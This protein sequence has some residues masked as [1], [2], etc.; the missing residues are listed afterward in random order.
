MENKYKIHYTPAL[1]NLLKE[2]KASVLITT[3]QAGKLIAISEK[4]GEIHQLPVSFKKPMG[5][6]IHGKKLA[7][8]CIDEIQFFSREV[9]DH[10]RSREGLQDFDAIYLHRASYHTG[11]M[12]VHDMEFGDGMLWGV[13]TLFSC[14]GVYDINFSFRPKWKPPFISG[15]APEDRCHL[16]GMAMVN[17]MPKYVTA[18]SNDNTVQGWR[19]DKLRSGILMEVPSGDI[20]LENLSMPHSPRMYE[21]Q[22]YVLESGNGNLLK[23]DPFQKSKEVIFNF[24]CFV[25]GLAFIGDI[26]IIGKSKIRETSKDFNDLSVKENSKNAGVIFFHLRKREVIGVIN[27]DTNVEEIFDVQVLPDVLSPVLVATQIDKFNDIITLPGGAFWK[28]EEEEK[29]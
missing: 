19:K 1:S 8:A 26:A 2:L 14:I 27:Y 18:L 3:Y 6:A 15:L 4:N 20:I 22:L 11:I 28:N 17:Q 24:D 5:V 21:E 10:V 29:S 23:V 9:E 16:N 7:V 12:D 25:R 13:N